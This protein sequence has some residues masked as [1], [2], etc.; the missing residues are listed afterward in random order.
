MCSNFFSPLRYFQVLDFNFG[1]IASR[2]RQ[3]YQSVPFLQFENDNDDALDLPHLLDFHKE[4]WP[5][6]SSISAV[7]FFSSLLS[8]PV[9]TTR[10][11]RSPAQQAIIFIRSSRVL[12]TTSER[13]LLSS[14][15]NAF[16]F[17]PSSPCHRMACSETICLACDS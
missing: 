3:I 12:Q 15:K 16:S 4:Q 10:P 13:M 2:S 9:R 7:L 8:S 17:H 11:D 14:Q 5:C 6:R 1:R